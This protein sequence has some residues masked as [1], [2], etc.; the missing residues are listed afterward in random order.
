[1]RLP[2]LRRGR[3]LAPDE[4]F[5]EGR[6]RARFVDSLADADVER[7]NELLPWRC[8]TVDSRGRP[9]GG[10]A[11]RG[12][13]TTPQ[14]IPDPRVERF[15]ERFDLSDKHVLE[16]GCF[17]G[18]HTIALCRLAARVTAVDARVENVVKTVVRCAFYDERPRVFAYD[19][20]D[21][22]ADDELLR[23][24]VCHHVGVLY[25]LVD[26]VS[27]LERLGR[28]ISR[29]LMLDTHYAREDEVTDEYEVDGE[30]FRF[31]RYE[32]RGRED[33]FSGMRRHSKWLLL[34]DI[35]RVLSGVGFENVDVAERRDE[36]NGP[37]VLLF[38]ERP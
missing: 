3:R 23:A 2:A 24:D 18:V 19:V 35:E 11:W 21:A 4:R 5:D 36:R 33:V 38:A 32:E 17:E 1:M 22:A 27:H 16:V 7:L 8:F 26:P 28:W 9:F 37:R 15:H 29:G 14:R 13:R 25:H 20:E 30:R 12:K 31:R 10:V 6:T 34:K